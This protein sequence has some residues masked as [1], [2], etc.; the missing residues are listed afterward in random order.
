MRV[1][2]YH[3][4]PK[5]TKITKLIR[6]L[7]ADDFASAEVKKLDDNLYRAKV[8]YAGRIIFSLYRYQQQ[9]CCLLLEYLPNH[10]YEKSRFLRRDVTIDESKIALQLV[11]P[12]VHAELAYVNPNHP[13][14]HILDKIICFDDEQQAIHRV[15]APLLI[16]GSAGSGKT[17]LSLEKMKDA[18]GNV[19][20]VSR[21]SFLVQNARDLYYSHQYDNADQEIDFL[22]FA[23]FIEQLKVPQGQ[24]MNP[25]QFEDWF[26]R[27][28]QGTGLKDAHKVFEEIRGVLTGSPGESATDAT[29]PQ[30]AQTPAWGKAWLSRS[31]YL[32]LGIKQSIFSEAE[33]A[34]VYDLFEKY[35]RLLREQSLYDINILSH[36]YLAL[37]QP[38]YDFVV[39]DEVQDLT[40]IQL[41]LILKTLREPTQFI[42]CGD[43]NQIV[44]PNFFSWAKI[45]TLLLKTLALKPLLP[46]HGQGEQSAE[47]MRILNSNYRNAAQV[48]EIANRLLKLKHARFGSIDKESNYLVKAVGN[49]PGTVTLLNE[50]HALVSELNTKTA[51]S[52]RFAVLVMYAEQKPAAKQIFNTP[53][54]F[55]IQEAK[56]LEYD[57]IILYNFVSEEEKVFRDIIA[58]VEN[59]DLSGPLNYA[60]NKDKSDKSLEVYKFFINALYVA[61]TRAIASL[62]IIERIPAHA[63]FPLLG[64]TENAELTGIDDAKSSLE[65]W[66]REARKLEL[67]GKTEQANEIRERLLNQKDVPWPVY[68]R[69]SAKALCAAALT[70]DNKKQRLLATEYAIFNRAE[71]VIDD[72][73]R[74]DFKPARHRESCFKQGIDNHFPQYG[75]KNTVP[76]IRETEKYGIDFRHSFNWTPLMVASILGNETLVAALLDLGADKSK[77]QNTGLTAFL[78][79]LQRAEHEPKYA[80]AVLPKLF[81]LLRPNSISVQVDGHL[82]KIDNHLMEFMMFHVAVL[83][84]YSDL[85][86]ASTIMSGALTSESFVAFINKMPL[87][88]VPE[89]K[90]KKSYL[91]SLLSKNEYQ[92]EDRYNRKLF[93]RLRRGHYVLNPKLLIKQ[94]DAWVPIYDFLDLDYVYCVA[95]ERRLNG[96]IP[97][98]NTKHMGHS[99][100]INNVTKERVERLRLTLRTLSNQ[101]TSVT[102]LDEPATATED[103]ETQ[104]TQT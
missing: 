96:G 39:V 81:S 26:A 4:L 59:I 65:E 77:V 44:H 31:E 41:F 6:M 100:A 104:T 58:G 68:T 74:A 53:L 56:G 13:Q 17:A 71:Q 78:L 16:I 97:V 101:A 102:T 42:L 29:D 37:A 47:L 21:S 57:N 18:I 9:T 50:R 62:Y 20:Y 25:R 22:S 43:S 40:P 91:S 15:R 52:T 73:C 2:T 46:Q 30:D 92:R 90:R 33:R 24:E 51:R 89:Q 79:T 23:E 10:E 3:E 98:G 83:L 95:V 99:N 60:R 28:R 85:G 34:A 14:F 27:N 70:E 19:L 63:M 35:L 94:D 5:S 48:T 54:V 55:S 11:P 87:S 7:E 72:F 61:I 76:V 75:T 64:I 80:A 38:C 45:K 36:E 49:R 12:S 82:I 88:I 93:L 69:S 8:D 84:T 32:A 103:T 1:L 67:Q 66:Q 86:L